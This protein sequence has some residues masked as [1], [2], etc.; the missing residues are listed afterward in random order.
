MGPIGQ[1]QKRAVMVFVVFLY[2]FTID[3]L[4]VDLELPWLKEADEREIGAPV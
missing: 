2:M 3:K 4:I 1:R